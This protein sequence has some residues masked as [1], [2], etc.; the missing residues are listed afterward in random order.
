[1][2]GI[3][4]KDYNRICEREWTRLVRDPFHRLEFDTTLFVLN[5]YLPRNALILDAGA[6]LGRYTIEL[7]KQGH[8]LILLDLSEKNVALAKQKIKEEGL[9]KKVKECVVGSLTDLSRLKTILLMQC[10]A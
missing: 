9:D 3:T 4:R 8:N 5:K 10:F 2:L 7:A 1:M 6:G